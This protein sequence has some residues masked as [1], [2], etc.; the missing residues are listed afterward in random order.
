VCASA[1]TNGKD[2]LEDMHIGRIP[3]RVPV[4]DPLGYC[5]LDL[6]YD[7]CLAAQESQPLVLFD[8]FKQAY[9]KS[10]FT[11]DQSS[12]LSAVSCSGDLA[13]GVQHKLS[14]MMQ[15]EW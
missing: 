10:G 11:P 6:I 5:G 4:L 9:A 15:N 13:G 3:L 7:F 12:C 8:L 1:C 2:Y 14:G